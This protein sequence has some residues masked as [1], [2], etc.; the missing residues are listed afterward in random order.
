MIDRILRVSALAFREA[1]AVTE[2]SFI[3]NNISFVL[4]LKLKL[5]RSD[6]KIYATTLRAE[7]AQ[8]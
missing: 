2:K 8:N 4:A 5:E 6:A 7:H 1:G 3:E